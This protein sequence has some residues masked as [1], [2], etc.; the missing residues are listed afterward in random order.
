MEQTPA[1]PRKPRLVR[2]G[3]DLHCG[4]TVGI[5][6]PGMLTTEGN[7]IGLNPIQK[8]L[9]G[10]WED[11]GKWLEDVAGADPYVDIWNGDLTE[12]RHHKGKQLVSQEWGDHL[13]PA[14]ALLK[15]CAVKAAKTF[16]T[17]GT[18]CH[19]DEMETVVGKLIGAERCPET[20]R[21][22]FDRLF[23]RMCGVLMSVRHHFP[24]TTRA[25][26]EASQHSIQLGN[27]QLEAHRH[28]LEVPRIVI[29]AHR[30]RMGHWSDGKG[31]SVVTPA[32]Q[33]LTHHGL[34]VVPDGWP[35]PGFYVLDWRNRDDGELPEVR[36]CQY[37]PAQPTIM[38]P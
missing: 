9:W 28:G 5:L 1:P 34:K 37:L 14:V 23:L 24:A 26:L 11:A 20:G 8:W 19:V 31:L 36:F 18:E 4:S 22:V 3:S 38:E 35:N 16:L 30:H 32:W 2:I 12:G 17:R 27:A 33:A 13:D 15:P 29:G 7:E 21:H 10:K 6:P 25:Y